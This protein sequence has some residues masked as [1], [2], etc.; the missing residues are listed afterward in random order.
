MKEFSITIN[1]QT[2]RKN[3]KGNW[4]PFP[5]IRVSFAPYLNAQFS[6]NARATLYTSILLIV[7][8]CVSF[9]NRGFIKSRSLILPLDLRN[10]PKISTLRTIEALR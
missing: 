4:D 8:D 3:S 1:T 5:V 2:L 6:A 9:E 7:I 10:G